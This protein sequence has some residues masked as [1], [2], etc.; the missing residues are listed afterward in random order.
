[1]EYTTTLSNYYLDDLT[2]TNGTMGI[3]T[4]Y[5]YDG[6]YISFQGEVKNDNGKISAELFFKY[7]KKKFG[8]LE[9]ARLKSRLDKIE[10][11]FY[12][13][14]ENGQEML[15]D[16]LM[17]ELMRETRESTLYAK[18][19][20]YF[21]ERDDIV[22]WKYRIK[23]G[24]ISDT[25]FKDYTR[26]IPKNILDK[27][28]KFESVFDDFIIYHYYNDKTEKEIEQKQ[29]MSQEEKSRMKDPVL[30]GIIKETNRLYFIAD[31][32][33]EYCDLRFDEIVDIIGKDDDEITLTREI[34]LN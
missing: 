34:K 32:E 9:N 21:I 31:W 27:K 24:H 1:M 15:G 8:L 14:V 18:G 33:D 12:K 29:K 20:R 6:P 4:N 26:V 17:K 25:K 23:E 3:S 22:K 11:A 13:A 2:S 28:K 16:K 10:K 5:A 7:A 19:I 30:F